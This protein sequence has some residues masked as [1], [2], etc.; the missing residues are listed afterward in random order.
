MKKI[1]STEEL[2]E[3]ILLLEAK[4]AYE[5]ALLKEQF[6]ITYESLKPANLIKNA[7]NELTQAPDLKADLMGTTM[8]LAAGYLS[9]KMAIGSTSNPFK[10]VLGTLLQ[11]GVTSIVSKNA[12]GIK[13][14][15]MNL[16]NNFFNKKEETE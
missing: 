3:S 16:M 1:T 11:M 6:K 8:S 12:D 13:S 10:Q 5:G 7:L 2:R 4:Q 9:K 14:A 15:A